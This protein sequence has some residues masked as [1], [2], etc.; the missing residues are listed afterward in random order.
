MRN[1]AP[2]G[3][4]PSTKPATIITPGDSARDVVA[5]HIQFRTC[6]NLEIVAFR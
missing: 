1:E 6:G 4:T 2:A 5:R 3:P